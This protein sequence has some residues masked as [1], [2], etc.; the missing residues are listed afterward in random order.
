MI[1]SIP[2]DRP[3]ENWLGAKYSAAWSFVED[4]SRVV[5]ILRIA[6]PMP[7]GL[8]LKLFVVSLWK[9]TLSQ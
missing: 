9:H 4:M 7:I 6:V 8:M 5:A 1:V 3:I 2:E